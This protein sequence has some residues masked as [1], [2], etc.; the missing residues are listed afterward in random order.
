MQ[1]AVTSQNRKTITEH[2]GKCRK[3]WIYSIAD[4]SIT[5]KQLIELPIEQSFHASH[6][7]LAAPL[8]AVNVL[9]TASMGAGLYQ[10]LQRSGIQALITPETDPD[11]AVAA[12]L[13]G[14]LSALT[15]DQLPPCHDHEHE[16][17]H[18]HAH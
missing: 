12:F 6:H 17:H 2:A 13:D 4:G 10:R 14:S 9:I 15:G 18:D 5:G 16:H 1:I 3:F 11:I 8:A 7:S